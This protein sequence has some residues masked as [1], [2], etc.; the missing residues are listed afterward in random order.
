M[1][2]IRLPWPKPPLSQNDRDER[3]RG[4]ARKIAD[5]KAEAR[6]AVRAGR[7]T[8]VD[9]AEVT[10]HYRVP[11]RRRRDAD[12]LAVVLKVCQDALVLEGVLADDSWTHIPAAT[13]RIH[14]PD[15]PPAMWLTLTPINEPPTGGSSVSR[16][17]P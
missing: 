3:T 8:P 15:G 6:W 16:D 9:R 17:T 13:C 14:P 5:A 11:D 4:G 2:T 7:V 10:L 1:V 12:N